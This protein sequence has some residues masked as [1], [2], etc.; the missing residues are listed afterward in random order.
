MIFISYESGSK[1][2]QFWDKDNQ[3]IIISCD[4]KFNESIFPIRKDLDYK[5]PFTDEKRQSTS[6]ENWNTDSNNSDTTI[7]KGLVIPTMSDSDDHRPSQ[8]APHP[9]GTP[10]LVPPKS[11]PGDKH[12]KKRS[13]K[14]GKTT[15]PDEKPLGQMK[16]LAPP[17][18]WNPIH[19]AVYSEVQDH[20]TICDHNAKW[21]NPK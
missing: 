1:G 7:N 14:T 4:V 17:F 21:V 6:V 15:R 10:P 18:H 11:S 13:P 19:K 3:S 16:S 9:P 12:T 5:N 2:Y 20:D 8:P